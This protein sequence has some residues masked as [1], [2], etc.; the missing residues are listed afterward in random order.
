MEHLEALNKVLEAHTD[1][2]IKLKAKKTFLF[3]K[4]VDFLG[5]RRHK[6]ERKAPGGHPSPHQRE[7][8]PTAGGVSPIL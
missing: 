8:G 5:H 2:G 6:P 7:G 4:A 1:A 3:K